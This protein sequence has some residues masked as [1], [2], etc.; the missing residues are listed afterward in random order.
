M[1]CRKVRD[2]ARV[3]GDIELFKKMKEVQIKIKRGSKRVSVLAYL[4]PCLSFYF[5]VAASLYF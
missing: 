3:I 2:T 5:V 4:M 1:T